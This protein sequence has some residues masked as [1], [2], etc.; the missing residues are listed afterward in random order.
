LGAAGGER[1]GF[2]AGDRCFYLDR[3]HVSFSGELP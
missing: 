2:R 3:T 1:A